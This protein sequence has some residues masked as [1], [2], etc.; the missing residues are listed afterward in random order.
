MKFK[1]K[2]LKVKIKKNNR[3]F[4]ALDI[5]RIEGKIYF[6]PLLINLII[7]AVGGGLVGYINKNS[8]EVYKSLDKPFFTP[9]EI[10]FPIIWTIV[11]IVMGI[12]AYRVYIKN[13]IK[14]FNSN[15]YFYYIIQLLCNFAWTFIFF[16]FRLY[17]LSFLWIIVISILATITTLKFLRVDKIAG[18]L[19]SPYILWLIFAGVLNYFIWVLNEM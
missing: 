9:P 2:K 4:K 7:P 8:F 14:G 12:A 19:M 17:G 6:I 18:I 16:T 11:Y 10:I 5:F 13:K 1:K 3:K 15:G